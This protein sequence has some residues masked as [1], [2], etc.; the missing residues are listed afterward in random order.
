M[1]AP[2]PSTLTYFLFRFDGVSS[3]VYHGALCGFINPESICFETYYYHSCFTKKKT[4]QWGSSHSHN[5]DGLSYDAIDGMT[6]EEIRSAMKYV[7]NS[8][9][10]SF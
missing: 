9:R 10:S 4:T 6:V 8:L 3:I 2:P 1:F 7:T 5:Y